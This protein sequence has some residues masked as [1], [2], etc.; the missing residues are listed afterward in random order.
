MGEFKAGK[1][2]KYI[3]SSDILERDITLSIYLPK[4]LLNYLSL[5]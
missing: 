2:N 5:R 4:I 3:L 1:I